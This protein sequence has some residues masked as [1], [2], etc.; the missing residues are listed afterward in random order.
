MSPR[1][2]GEGRK[3]VTLSEALKAFLIQKE[4]DGRSKRTIGF[5]EGKIEMFI[6][7]VGDKPVKDLTIQD[8]QNFVLRQASRPRYEGHKFKKPQTEPMSRPTLRGYVRAIKV[9]ASYLFD[10]GYTKTNVFAKIRLPKDTQRVVDVLSED[11]IKRLFEGVNPNTFHG[12]RMFAILSL[13]LD[14]G[15]RVG[16]LERIAFDDIDFRQSRVK[17]TGKGDKE[18]LVPFGVTT[19][20][21]ILRWYNQHREEDG[22]KRLFQTNQHN[23]NGSMKRLGIKV[24]IPRL[25]PHLTRHTFAVRWLR[26]GGDVFALQQVLGHSDISVTRVYISLAQ[27]DIENQHRSLSPIDRL[28][29]G[30][31]I[32]SGRAS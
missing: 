28:G 10:E 32:K 31:R 12:A 5:Y 24:G 23:I 30:R 4:V 27:V 18:R 29:I 3:M 20:K 15:M 19:S 1:T 13:L 2:L 22:D 14:T 25:H 11:E 6:G 7:F 9:W 17:V 21:A 16:E 8:G 26:G